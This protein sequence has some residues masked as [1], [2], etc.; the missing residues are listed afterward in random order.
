RI[1]VVD[2][3]LDRAQA[4]LAEIQAAGG[5]GLALHADVSRRADVEAAA[6]TAI[7]QMGR[8]DILV[9]NAAIAEGDDILT[10]DEAT[11]D[12]NL[13]VVLKSVYLCSRALLPDMLARGRGAIVNIA[14]VN[15]LTGLGEEPYSAAKAGVVNLTQN[16]AVCY[17]R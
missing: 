7:Q 15:G 3:A 2:H 13:A 11:W 10:I 8:V 17:G 5:A 12:L 1:A 16:L 6:H 9:N 14:S 4:T